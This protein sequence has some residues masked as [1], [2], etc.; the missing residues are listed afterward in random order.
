MEWLL[1]KVVWK[2]GTGASCRIHKGGSALF[3][4]THDKSHKGHDE[5]DDTKNL[6]DADGTSSD[7]AK[8]EQGGDQC[9]DQKDNG[10]V[11]HVYLL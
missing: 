6:G 1:D 9:D 8:A 7:A 5:E 11:Q 10:V 4:Q 3:H 2:S